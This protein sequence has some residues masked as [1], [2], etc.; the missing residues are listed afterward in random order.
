M[1]RRTHLGVRAEGDQ[2]AVEVAV[3]LRPQSRGVGVCRKHEN[4]T[5]R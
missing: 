1:T 3:D 4:G 5:L 2:D